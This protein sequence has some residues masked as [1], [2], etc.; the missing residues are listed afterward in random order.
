MATYLPN[1]T[2]V[3][4]EPALFTPD[5]SF[6]DKMLRRRQGLYEQGFAQVNSAYN[7]INRAV[8]NPYSIKLKDS[9]LK[10]AQENLK[11]LSALDLSQQQNV[12]AARSVFEP[13]VKNKAVLTDMAF[14]D[15]INQQEAIAESYRLKDGG[16]EFSSINL[17]DVTMQRDAFAMDSIDKVGQ[18]YSNRRAYTP[19]RDYKS[20]WAEAMKNFKPSNSPRVTKINDVRYDVV[21]DKSW[22]KEELE[23]YLNGVIDDKDKE[24]IAIEARVKFG[25]DPS[26]MAQAYVQEA[27]QTIPTLEAHINS[28]NKQI[29]VEKNPDDKQILED[30]KKYYE[31]KKEEL[32]NNI[33]A[34]NSGDFSYLQANKDRLAQGLYLSKTVDEFAKAFEHKDMEWDM[35]FDSYAMEV[36]KQQQEWNRM[37]YKEDRADQRESLKSGQ[38]IPVSVPADEVTAP[39]KKSLSGDVKQAESVLASKH[40][41]LQDHI[42][43]VFGGGR[44][45]G[46]ISAEEFAAYMKQNPGDKMVANY[47]R[48][49]IA[50]TEKKEELQAFDRNAERYAREVMDEKVPG[51]YDKA[52]AYKNAKTAAYNTLNNN[53]T[54]GQMAGAAAPTLVPQQ[55]L[56]RGDLRT[57]MG[58]DARQRQFVLA[59]TEA[60]GRDAEAALGLKPGEGMQ[61]L[62]MYNN[63]VT[64]YNN[65]PKSKKVAVSATG[66]QIPTTH[67]VWKTTADYLQQN[68]GIDV[69]KISGITYV[70][71]PNGTD[72][73]FTYTNTKENKI[74]VEKAMNV[75]Q[76]RFPSVSV[77][78][79]EETGVVTVKGLGT[80]LAPKLDPYAGVPGEHR[81]MLQR[82]YDALGPAG[83]HM[84]KKFIM[85][86]KSGRNLMFTL[87]KTYGNTTEGDG[88]YLFGDGTSQ[89]LVAEKFDN[90]FA[91]YK[92]MNQLLLDKTPK[93]LDFIFESKK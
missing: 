17:E 92:L 45:G 72:I 38:I 1:V 88:Y 65:N 52:I 84:D 81:Q 47:I 36:Y 27:S 64:Q 23:K 7:F 15:F 75:L 20:R 76:T 8:T 49:Q 40:K 56:S 9:F 83:S 24:Q 68:S 82:L 22:Y 66:L 21:Q 57:N 93:Q 12:D 25:K 6:L 3:F 58:I 18:Y 29:G 90:V 71:K 42:A 34:I 10:Q 51:T 41:E 5:F 60:A 2:D 70:P 28:L 55:N 43:Q 19:Y 80:T 59:A 14:T 85:Q 37:V 61:L 69:S 77:T 26:A 39:T 79:N 53:T 78:H 48:Q 86:D 67:P 16:K 32:T 63:L 46:S 30:N 13:F 87:R 89:P 73:A 54:A 50:L 33:L 74:N 4:P 35:K 31:T 44:T 91:P 11:N 62:N